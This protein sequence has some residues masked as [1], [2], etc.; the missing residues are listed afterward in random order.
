MS[1]QDDIRRVVK[2]DVRFD[3]P[4]S[5]HTS[6]RIGGPADIFICPSD[7]EDLFAVLEIARRRSIP[8]C[9]IGQGTNILV[10]DKG[11]RGMVM[12]MATKP[13]RHR[14]EPKAMAG[15]FDGAKFGDDVLYAGGG[16]RLG[17]LVKLAA[18]RSLSGLEFAVGIPGT[19]GGAIMTNAGLK[20]LVIGGIVREVQVVFFDGTRKTLG[21]KDLKFGYRSS[22]LGKEL[23]LL[24]A[25][26][27]LCE[28]RASEILERMKEFMAQRKNTQPLSLPNAGC[29]FKNPPGD[30][31][32]R[33]IEI[34]GLK[35]RRVGEAVISVKH[36]NF[37]QNLGRA[38][39]DHVIQLMDKVRKLV[40]AR[41]GVELEPEIEICGED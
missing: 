10:R 37:V 18:N 19:L 21:S 41:A 33:L 34:S 12:K 15:G 3:E 5:R 32:G 17:R 20:L 30:S 26:L 16:A 39:A 25:G 14:P 38:R 22:D 31:A 8:L 29:I 2:G 23:V 1:L 4:M 9:I 24:S 7:L 27:Q 13:V 35:G 11:I 28:G 40:K 6:F 36:A